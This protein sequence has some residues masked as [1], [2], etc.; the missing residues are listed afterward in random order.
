MN[1]LSSRRD[2]LMSMTA[3]SLAGCATDGLDFLSG[4]PNLKVGLLSDIH[5]TDWDSTAVL[6]KALAWFDSN[7]VD[8]VLIAGDLADH[9]ILLQLEIVMKAW[10]S[11][12]PNDR[13]TDGRKVERVFVYGN[14]DP[15][16]LNYRDSFMDAAFA[17]HHL[18]YEEAAKQRLDVLGLDTCWKR[19]F[20]EDYQSVYRKSVKGYDFIGG[21][22][23]K[24]NGSGWGKG[25][26]IR[27]F[28]DVV[29]REIDPSKPFFFVQH[30]HPLN[31]CF[32]PWAW[33]HDAGITTEVLSRYPN[34]V[35]FSGHAHYS[36]TDERAVWRESFTSV[37]LP[38]LSYVSLKGG[39]RQ[40]AKA[41]NQAVRANVGKPGGN[42]QGA[43]MS[44][45]D[46]RIVIERRDFV[47]DVRLDEAWCFA[48]PT[49]ASPFS[50]R[51][52][53]SGAPAFAPGAAVK[54]T[55]K[56]DPALRRDERE[57]TVTL[58]QALA[59]AAR[60]WDYEL[61][62]ELRHEDVEMFRHAYR[63]SS[64]T[65]ALPKTMDAATPSFDV[66]L[67]GHDFGPAGEYRFTLVAL[68]CYGRRS[69]PIV[70]DWMKI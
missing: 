46:D 59:G 8:A 42:Q 16:G 30:P 18:S 7:K 62:V 3:F 36:L 23:D 54:V 35:A 32:G 70:S 24:A 49:K 14:H 33:G 38:S 65:A 15:E 28:F 51:A 56:E 45:F 19:V 55:R 68:N 29:G 20:H 61:T 2:F 63:L 6:R 37:G 40:N 50:A 41:I 11:V 60:P 21:H 34:A 64:P 17:V 1:I 26:N 43:L 31:T 57:L 52:A 67:P 39:A 53:K 27:P 58:P 44:V 4:S 5:I 66:I 22:W 13:A 12:F 47:R 10:E 69:E 25:P 48:T 9:G